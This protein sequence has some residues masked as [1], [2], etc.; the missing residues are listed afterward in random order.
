VLALNSLRPQTYK[1]EE[2]PLAD[3][4]VTLFV[5]LVV[6]CVLAVA[7]ITLLVVLVRLV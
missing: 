3:P 1:T 4:L 7:A 2:C 5:R 6:A